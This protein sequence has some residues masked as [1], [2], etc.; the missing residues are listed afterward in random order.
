[1]VCELHS[2]SRP[3]VLLRVLLGI[4]ALHFALRIAAGRN[5]S[6]SA[7]NGYSLDEPDDEFQTLGLSHFL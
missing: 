5:E 7:L 2:E 6:S 3:T 1:V 4:A